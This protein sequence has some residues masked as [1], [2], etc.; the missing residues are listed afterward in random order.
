[1]V[2]AIRA[3]IGGGFYAN[4]LGGQALRATNRGEGEQP[5]DP[6]VTNILGKLQARFQTLPS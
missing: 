1:M 4:L 2:D 6:H 5:L 3:V